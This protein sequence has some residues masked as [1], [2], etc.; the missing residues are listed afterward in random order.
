MPITTWGRLRQAASETATRESAARRGY[1][2]AW[3]RT[4][5]RVLSQRPL[6]ED[7]AERGDVAPATEVHHRVKIRV[8][9][10]RKHD[11]SNL[12]AL[13]AECHATRTA[14]GE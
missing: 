6:C 14:A 11:A 4:R 7:C 5:L 12:V 10:E 8:A 9:P 1:D 3:Q 13:C 2:R